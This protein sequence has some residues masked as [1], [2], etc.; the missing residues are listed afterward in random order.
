MK[1]E[2]VNQEEKKDV[3]VEEEKENGT[4][5]FVLSDESPDVP[6][7]NNKDAPVTEKLM[8]EVRDSCP[9]S[10]A[11]LK[12]E[13]LCVETVGLS[14]AQPLFFSMGRVTDYGH[15]FFLFVLVALSVIRF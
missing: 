5:H 10:I 11:S 12:D 1:T 13:L 7:L 6:T 9:T 14:S 4:S 15:K 2:E 3:I 8:K